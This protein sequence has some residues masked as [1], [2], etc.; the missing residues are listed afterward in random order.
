MF[1]KIL[2]LPIALLL[3]A[4]LAQGWLG[5]SFDDNRPLTVG[6]VIE[7]SP[8]AKA[9]VKVGDVFRAVNGRRIR[10]ED[11]LVEMFQAFESGRKIKL[12]MRR[13]DRDVELNVTLAKEPE[14]VE[15]FRRAARAAERDRPRREQPRRERPRRE[16]P[17]RKV[18]HLAVHL[19]P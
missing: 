14:N 12:T 18:A 15:A 11:Q 16:Q 4:P 17:R 3:S 1:T 5:I 19:V 9:G 2:S 6:D 7:G 13:G 8:A 10:S